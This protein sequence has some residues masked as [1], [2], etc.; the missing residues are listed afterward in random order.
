MKS[1]SYASTLEVAKAKQYNV[2]LRIPA[3]YLL[4]FEEVP[5]WMKSGPYIQ[6]GYRHQLHSFRACFQSL[7]YPHNE[8]VNTWSHL[9]PGIIFLALLSAPGYSLFQGGLQVLWEDQLVVQSFFAGT[10]SC[11]IFSVCK[12]H[13]TD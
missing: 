11:L 4:C 2:E 3:Q 12:Q 6:R 7:L 8:L 1:R 13:P 5:Q 9:L 10:A